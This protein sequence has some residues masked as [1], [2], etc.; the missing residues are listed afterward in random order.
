MSNRKITTEDKDKINLTQGVL[1]GSI[2]G[3]TLWNV[4]CNTE[5]KL[6]FPGR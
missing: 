5:L 6:D 3:P 1:K 2:L 4:L